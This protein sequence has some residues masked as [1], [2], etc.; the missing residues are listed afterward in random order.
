[1]DKRSIINGIG[2]PLKSQLIA[3]LGPELDYDQILKDYL[4]YQL[5]IILQGK[6]TAFSL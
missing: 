1:M 2:L 6:G 5:S 4:Q 3:H